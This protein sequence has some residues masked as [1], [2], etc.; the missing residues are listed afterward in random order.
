MGEKESDR[1]Y[2]FIVSLYGLGE[3]GTE[4]LGSHVEEAPGLSGGRME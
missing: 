3:I 1:R 4:L 2:G